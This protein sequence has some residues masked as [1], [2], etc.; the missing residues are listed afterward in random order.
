MKKLIL[1][2]LFFLFLFSCQR[3]P[4]NL[5]NLSHDFPQ[6]SANPQFTTCD[7]WC[8]NESVQH[9]DR[10]NA[11]LIL[12]ENDDMETVE[13]FPMEKSDSCLTCHVTGLTEGSHY[14]Y[15]FEAYTDYD[16]FRSKD[17]YQFTTKLHQNITVTTNEVFDISQTTAKGRGTIT[18]ANGV[19]ATERGMCWDTMHNPTIQNSHLSNGYGAG[20]FIVPIIELTPGTQYYIRSYSINTANGVTYGNEMSFST[21]SA[22]LPEVVSLHVSNITATSAVAHGKVVSEGNSPVTERG[23]CWSTEHGPLV[24]GCHSSAGSGLGTFS[25]TISGLT[26]NATYYI[27]SYA[28]NAQGITY[29]AEMNFTVLE[30][31]PEVKTLPATNVEA[32]TAV[33]QGEVLSQGASPII[34]R[35]ICWSIKQHP[36]IEDAH[37]SAGSGIGE[38]KVSLMGLKANTTYYLRAYASNEFGTGYGEEVSMTTLCL[39]IVTTNEVTDI[40]TNSAICWGNVTNQGD[41]PVTERGVCWSTEHEPTI[42]DAHASNGA[43]E[44]S[45]SCQ[46]SDLHVRKTYFIRSYATSN[47]GTAYG[48]EFKFSTNASLP[49][50][51]TADIFNITTNS[52]EGGGQVMDD[53]GLPIIA[54]GICWSTTPTPTIADAHQAIN[55]GMNAFTI[56]MTNLA[57]DETYYVRAFATNAEGVIYGNEVNFK[58]LDK[59]LPTVTTFSITNITQTTATGGGN[60]TSDGNTTVTSRGICW[61]TSPNPTISD[62]HTTDG[63]GTGGFSTNM[64][65][66]TTNTMYYVRA[67]ATNSVG[68]SYGSQLLF[69]TQS[70]GSGETLAFTANGVSFEMIEVKGGTFWMGAQSN[71][72]SGQ[73]YDSEAYGYE[74]PVHQVTLS[75]YHIGKFEVTQ[76]LWQA[77]MGNNP[78]CFPG[79]SQRP[80][81]RVSWNDCQTFITALNE[82]CASQ[83][84]GKHFS[85]PTEAQWEFAA[86]GGDQS[87]GYKYSGSNTID[88]VAWYG[89]TSGSTHVVGTKMPN[90][91]GL[92]DMSGNVCEWCSDWWDSYG[93]SAQTDPAGPSSGTVLVYRGGSWYN[94]ARICRVSYRNDY[95]PDHAINSLGLRLS[96][97]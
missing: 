50:V 60:V 26:Q 62:S 97:R 42:N 39:P 61:S 58:T 24:S 56:S 73:N 19:M 74:E 31:Q 36:S 92:Y 86:K 89:S 71:N 14:F 95:L 11:R 67:Y 5:D 54:C 83:L 85:L 80:V 30:G 35:G 15:T 55:G 8:Q 47:L 63:S 43:G 91:L 64:T 4:E 37:Q 33:G 28:I 57:I 84:N 25:V 53:G 70:G 79:N 44:G 51:T 49:I 69:I 90:E 94:N 1:F 9:N 77:V 48:E 17:K 46:V 96:L 23:V 12:S 76:E 68:T 87:H 41:S 75:S 18:I 27:R 78:S 34:E 45:Y 59:S 88:D 22:D 93:S 6:V 2:Q 52:A 21:N 10:V 82:L 20:E 81:E 32:I 13:T 29:G 66:L 16:N 40:T 72:P 3:E 65:G 7:I 38:Y